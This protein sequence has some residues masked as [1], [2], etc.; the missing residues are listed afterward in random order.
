MGLRSLNRMILRACG[1]ALAAVLC[2]LAAAQPRPDL[3]KVLTLAESRTGPRSLSV[4]H[5]SSGLWQ[6]LLRLGTTASVLYTI[7]HPDDEQG[8]ALTYL[9]RGQG[10]RAAMLTLN[11]GEAGANAVGPELFDALGLIRTEEMLVSDRY[12]GLDDQY[13]TTLIDYGYSKNLE[14]ALGQWGREN[15]LRDVVRVI[16]I[17]RPLVLVSR[18]YG[19][20]RDGHGNHEASGAITREAYLA[21]GDPDRFPEQIRDEGLRPWQPLK[22]YRSNLRSRRVAG[23]ESAPPEHRWNVRINAGTF[24]P[25]LGQTYEE[26]AALG[27]SFQRSQ[28]SGRTRRR[29]GAY[30]HYFE[31]L[32]AQVETPDRESGFF[33]GI[34]TS[35]TG[36]FG[37]TGAQAPDGM[38]ELL[39]GIEGSIRDA[40]AAYSVSNPSAVVPYLVQGLRRTRE[41]VRMSS[42]NH[43]A[44]FLLAIKERQFQDAIT[45]ALGIRL[46][47]VAVPFG[48]DRQ[49]SPFSARATMGDVVPGQRFS[50]DLTLSSSGSM[51]IHVDQVALKSEGGWQVRGGRRAGVDPLM[52]ETLAARFEVTVPAE[53]APARRYYVRESVRDSRYSIREPR[54]LHLP[55]RGPALSAVVDFS[56]GGEAVRTWVR[57]HRQEANLPFGYEFRELKVAPAIAVNVAPANLIAPAGPG[58]AKVSLEVELHCNHPG[59]AE[60]ELAVELPDGWRAEPSKHAFKFSQ[61]NSGQRFEFTVTAPRIS[62]DRYEVR[63][64]ARSGGREYREGVLSIRHRDLDTRHLYSDSVTSVTGVNVKIAPQ[65]K[66]GYVMGVGDE[67]P[68]GIRQL[69]PEV[70][71]LESDA[72]AD[73]DLSEYGTIVVGTRAYAVREDL[74]SYNQ[75]LL[76]YARAGGNLVILYQTQEF[77]PGKWAAYPADLPRRAEEVSE[78]DSP[79]KVLAPDHPVLQVPNR[80]VAA[81]FE[82]W[83]EQRGSKFFA[84]WDDSYTPLIETQDQGQDPQRGGWLTARF[85]KGHYTYFAYA[86]H[87]QVP[88]SIPGAYRILANVLSLGR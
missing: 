23:S 74:I 4:D 54:F 66:V 63:V 76:D 14:E 58:P 46:R 22:L 61:A 82:N 27:L 3:E 56:I 34:D 2:A 62:E 81:D 72:L 83:V 13:F 24:S 17:N 67:V 21:A 64:V 84:S 15:A 48:S 41:A 38:T 77:D 68:S 55:G 12:Y 87:R 47:A 25:W 75:R 80:I 39:A 29:V 73:G 18:F 26:F 71:L 79:V 6:H 50:V 16:R 53:A 33:Q 52:E 9:S 49:G 42:Q 86:I 85:G 7:A 5:G 57:V 32:E 30:L 8:G 59:G 35:L 1:A 11:R 69:G 20:F 51:P 19:D 37:L 45:V 60:G 43:E 28:T 70:T 40:V 10:A 44:A 36:M 65:L 31:R 78:E 88:Y